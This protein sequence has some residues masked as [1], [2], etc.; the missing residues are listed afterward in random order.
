M[1]IKQLPQNYYEE[2]SF[3]YGSI[4]LWRDD[5]VYVMDNH[6]SAAWCWLQSCN[7]DCM[8]NFMH[9]DRHYDMLECFYDEDLKPIKDN[10][11]MSYME[12]KNLKQSKGGKYL[13][14]RWDNYIMPIYVLYPNWFCTNILLTHKEGDIGS[15]WGHKSFVFAE[16]NPLYMD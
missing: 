6:L 11:H 13:V 5:K 15:N 2:T 7:P 10:P 12:F 8:Y 14:F 4:M 16:E 1:W 9:I 3:C